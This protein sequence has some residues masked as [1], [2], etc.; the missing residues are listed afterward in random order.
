M[1]KSL[2][3]LTV[4]STLAVLTGCNSGTTYRTG[5]SHEQQTFE[6]FYNM[7]S[8]K[9]EE[10]K[11]ID[12]SSRPGLVLPSDQAAL[13]APAN[14]AKQVEQNWPVSPEQR[15]AG[16]RENAPKVDDRNGT[17][18]I[19]ERNKARTLF[20]PR[21]SSEGKYAE[22]PDLDRDPTLQTHLKEQKNR[23]SIDRDQLTYSDAK[24]R[25][26]L[27][28]PP[29][30]YRTPTATAEA[31]DLGYDSDLIKKLRKQRKK[32]ELEADKGPQLN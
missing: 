9:P 16:V 27:T 2:L 4:V 28:E 15:I 25:R 21:I 12:Y 10:K 23:Q 13:P 7:L 18:S 8:L 11:N 1:N 3:A 6:G 14:G 26:Y 22:T 29:T 20:G 19:E 32:A 31:G 24:T 30:E 5:V 17:I